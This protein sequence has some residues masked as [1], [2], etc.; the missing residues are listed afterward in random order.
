MAQG[1]CGPSQRGSAFRSGSL[2]TSRMPMLLLEPPSR[3]EHTWP[4]SNIDRN[5][6]DTD[7][8]EPSVRWR[9]TTPSPCDGASAETLVG[10]MSSSCTF[11]KA[12]DWT[13]PHVQVAT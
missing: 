1:A 7:L 13:G 5:A 12:T 8:H 2:Q 9:S 3:S 11:L 4:V 10:L 6:Y